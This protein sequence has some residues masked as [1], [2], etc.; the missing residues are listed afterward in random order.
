[1]S[2]LLQV[3]CPET[4]VCSLDYGPALLLRSLSLLNRGDGEARGIVIQMTSEPAFLEPKQWTVE[5]I[6]VDATVSID[7]LGLMAADQ[8]GARLAI[9]CDALLRFRAM[10]EGVELAEAS[11]TVSLIPPAPRISVTL[12]KS[13]N[14]AFQQNAIPLVKELLIQ[15]NGVIRRDLVFRISTE[16]PF[17]LPTEVRLQALDA[18]GRF[19]IGPPNLSLTLSPSYLAEL[20][21][22]VNGLLKIEMVEDGAVVQ[23]HCE[24]ISLLTRN[25]WCGLVALPEILAAFVLPNDPAVMEILRRAADLLKE[26]T[27][28][29]S[30]NGYQD[31]NR[32]RAWEQIAA[33]YKAVAEL[34]INYILSLI[35]I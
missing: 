16:P 31:K 35:H 21:E 27:G 3:D 18:A 15:N 33:I 8:F 17:A 12:D 5:S 1:M 32:N 25:E 30:L 19:R 14:Y 11:R 9:G 6:G 22:R 29:A 20:T 4:F 2:L 23:S 34:R 10:R 24:P 26:R 13:I 7:D 28:R